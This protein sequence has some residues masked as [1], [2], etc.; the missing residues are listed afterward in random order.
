MDRVDAIHTTI[1]VN[2]CCVMPSR[3]ITIFQLKGS[4]E[5]AVS[6]PKRKDMVLL[7]V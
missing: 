1:I 5:F 2:K 7:D 3:G 6:V 4:V